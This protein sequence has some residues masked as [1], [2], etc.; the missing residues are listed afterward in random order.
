MK[1]EISNSIAL[2]LIS[3]LIMPIL[4]MVSLLLLQEQ[5]LESVEILGLSSSIIS[6]TFRGEII[7]FLVAWISLFISYLLYLFDLK[8]GQLIVMLSSFVF[9]IISVYTSLNTYAAISHIINPIIVF[10][11]SG[12][13]LLR[14]LNKDIKDT[15]SSK[16][17]K[18]KEDEV[19]TKTTKK[20]TKKASTKKN[21]KKK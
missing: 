11:P 18:K 6:E 21:V 4:T 13:G 20:T 19:T 15:K 16:I 12:Y 10:I 7:L 5:M 1:R 9:L 14:P 2:Y 8:V 17:E 3:L